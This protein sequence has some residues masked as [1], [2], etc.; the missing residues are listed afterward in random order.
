MATQFPR[1]SHREPVTLADV[2]AALGVAP[3]EQAGADTRVSG[4]TH[5]SRQVQP[6]D[7]YAALPGARVHGAAFGT[8]AARDGAVAVLTDQTGAD[9]LADAGV[10]LPVLVVDDPRAAMGHAAAVVYADPA[11]REDLSVLGITG[12]N[13]KTTTAYL[14]DSALRELGETTG[15]I[16]TIETRIGDDRIKSSRTTPESS[17]LHA[18]LAVMAERGVTTCTMEVSSHALSLHRVDGVRFDV[19]AFLNLSQDHL[20]FY[21][22]MEDYFAAKATL[23]DPAL[24]RVGVVVVD[25][26]W[27]RRLARETALPI[28]TLS[29][30]GADADWQL[31][32]PAPGQVRLARTG[33][34]A[35]VSFASPLPGEF[36]DLNAAV[37]VLMLHE[38]GVDLER[39]ARAVARDPHVPGRM[40]RVWPV[41]RMDDAAGGVSDG[42][43]DAQT[44]DASGPLVVV[45][46]A[47][48]PDAVAM[49]LDA[50]RPETQ[51]RGGRV[52]AVLGAGGDRDRG[53]RPGMGRALAEH[54]DLSFVTD[55]NP[56]S[57]DPADIRSAMLAGVPEE[58]ADR[59]REMPGRA[60]AID[61]AVEAAQP[62]DTLIVLGKGHES[63]QEI[64]GTVH[65]FLD[66][67]VVLEAL[68]SR[69]VPSTP[70]AP[71][72]RPTSST[73]LEGTS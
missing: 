45:D 12:T 64:A 5:D 53:K 9:Q 7:L 20:D 28:V 44:G 16:G 51:A 55:D 46:F 3:V 15:I 40:E 23:L 4:L 36:N 72:T 43:D 57:E 32:R 58:L 24:A 52:I 26:E 73:S 59:V 1:P 30:T 29:S 13:G 62:Q 27:G 66:R 56:R 70:S 21:G 63:G 50:V 2:A 38:R 47:H 65:P 34:D 35:A 49:A 14:L 54:A 48:T 68:R 25:D 18:L 60:A 71:S 6:G 42:A 41:G 22:T 39:A 37:A 10:A 17:D 8:A 33:G 31:Q 11:R 19:V 69:S 61:A 67:D